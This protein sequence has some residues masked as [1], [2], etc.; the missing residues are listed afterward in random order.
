MGEFRVSGR[1]ENRSFVPVLVNLRFVA[2]Y[3]IR[4]SDLVSF[5]VGH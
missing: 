5:R 3:I 4:P 2:S 1:W